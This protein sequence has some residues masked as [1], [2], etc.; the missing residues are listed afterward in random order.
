LAEHAS[1]YTK[2]AELVKNLEGVQA[3]VK[4]IAGEF[5][6]NVSQL[7]GLSG[8]LKEASTVLHALSKKS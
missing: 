5:V 6:N 8:S 1:T 4:R 3:Q 7:D 2:L